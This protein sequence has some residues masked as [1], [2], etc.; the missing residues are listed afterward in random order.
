MLN[1]KAIIVP[2]TV[3]LTKIHSL[4]GG[5]FSKTKIIRRKSESWIRFE[6]NW[7][8]FAKGNDLAYL[9]STID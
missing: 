9:K 2:L 8:E 1:G 3:G 5:I 4:N 6:L 7:T